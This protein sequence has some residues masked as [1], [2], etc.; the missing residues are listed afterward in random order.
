MGRPD[1]IDEVFAALAHAA[2]RKI[3]DVVKE[4]PGCGV[5]DVCDHFEMTRIGV[6]KHL[7]ILEQ[8][9]LITSE[10][11]G[12]VRRLYFNAVPIQMIYDRWTTEFSA[13]WAAGLTRIKYRIESARGND[14][15][16]KPAARQNPEKR[17]RRHG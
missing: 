11:H 12:R 10:K 6:M 8:A 7:R 9:N 16:R 4:Q 14:A 15:T 17:K 5:H 3:L 13:Y 1:Q 2:R